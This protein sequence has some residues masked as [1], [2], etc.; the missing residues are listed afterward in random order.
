MNTD[1]Y[2]AFYDRFTLW[3]TPEQARQG[4]H[5]GK[6]DDDVMELVKS[7]DIKAQ[8]DT[9]AAEDI[10]AELHGFGAWDE[11]ELN[12]PSNNRLRIVWIACGDIAEELRREV[13]Q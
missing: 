11:E 8:L 2:P 6:C 5:P 3:M 13:I 12:N 7:P 10:K 9:I 1:K 4:S